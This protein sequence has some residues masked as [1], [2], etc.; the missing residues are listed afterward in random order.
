ML[1]FV[2]ADAGG[3]PLARRPPRRRRTLRV[4]TAQR[5]ARHDTT[6]VP[7]TGGPRGL[8]LLRVHRPDTV[9]AWLNRHPTVRAT[10]L[11][12]H[13]GAL[14]MRSHRRARS[15]PHHYHCWQ[16]GTRGHL[17]P[18]T[19]T[20]HHESFTNLYGNARLGP[21]R[22]DQVCHSSRLRPACPSRWRPMRGV[23]DIGA[24]CCASRCVGADD[25]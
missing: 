18:G 22:A 8:G 4:T 25:D 16:D 10:A 14:G 23:E 24:D 7:T 3:S 13:A 6:R 17:P 12:L 2:R 15:M 9:Y 1:L 21:H 19:V 5:N 20:Y 11:R